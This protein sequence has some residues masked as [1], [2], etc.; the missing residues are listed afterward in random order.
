MARIAAVVIGALSIAL[1]I[2][3][4]SL[5]VAFLVGLAF[6]VAASANV[7]SI[8]LT[9]FWRRFNTTGHG[10]RHDRSAWCRRSCSSSLSPAVMG[11]DPP[12]AAVRAPD[13][14]PRDLPAREP[15]RSS[16]CRSG[17][18]PRSSAR[19]SARS[20][21]RGGLQR[22]QRARQH[23]AGRGVTAHKRAACQSRPRDHDWRIHPCRVR[24]VVHHISRPR[25]FG[26]LARVDGRREAEAHRRRS[27]GHAEGVGARSHLAVDRRVD[28]DREDRGQRP[29][30]A[31][32]GGAP[33]PCHA[34]RQ[35]KP[36]P[37]PLGSFGAPWRPAASSAP[38]RWRLPAGHRSRGSGPR[39]KKA[40]SAWRLIGSRQSHEKCSCARIAPMDLDIRHLRLVAEIAD[41][42]SM[43]QGRRPALP[44]AVRPQ[45]SAPRHRSARSTRRSSS[46]SAGGWC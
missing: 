44:H 19:C 18:S 35:A 31:G 5:N 15:R 27:R 33:D 9:L 6:A 16:R 4:K 41:A 3:L 12:A 21:G 24:R 22:A 34:G 45:P 42:G 39:R 40:A 1:A 28:A 20:G 25:C 43:T 38:P 2:A 13:S 17:S 46:A 30:R 8:L 14:A 10:R 23:R 32:V 26:P 11:V 36:R 7:P 37:G 29:V